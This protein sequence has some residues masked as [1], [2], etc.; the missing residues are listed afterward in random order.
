MGALVDALVIAAIFAAPVL[1]MLD[2][3]RWIWKNRK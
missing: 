2:G 1:W 3:V